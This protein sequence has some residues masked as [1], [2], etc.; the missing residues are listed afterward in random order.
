MSYCLSV[1]P[2]SMGGGLCAQI[3]KER[4]LNPAKL[5]LQTVMIYSGYQHRSCEKAVKQNS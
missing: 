2:C 5:E 4:A 3:G 1:C